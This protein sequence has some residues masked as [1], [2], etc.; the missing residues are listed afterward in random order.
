[1]HYWFDACGLVV[2]SS[3]SSTH[4]CQPVVSCDIDTSLC[5]LRENADLLLAAVA[6][7]G[8]GA[9][10]SVAHL[11]NSKLGN[12]VLAALRDPSAWDKESPM[13]RLLLHSVT[14]ASHPVVALC[15]ARDAT[16]TRLVIGPSVG[17]FTVISERRTRVSRALWSNKP[18]LTRAIHP[19]T[20]GHRRRLVSDDCVELVLESVCAGLSKDTAAAAAS[21]KETRAMLGIAAAY[22]EGARDDAHEPVVSCA[23]RLLAAALAL[24]TKMLHNHAG[25]RALALARVLG[26]A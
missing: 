8:A 9:G 7:V 13:H 1:M 3:P 26:P 12:A 18:L 25:T 24:S 17:L 21:A 6:R 23:P 2:G 5:R 19:R 11:R 4:S 10:S 14:G 15:L 16:L 22:M 20:G